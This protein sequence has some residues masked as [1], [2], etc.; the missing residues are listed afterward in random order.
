MSANI[1]CLRRLHA[2]GAAIP[3][4]R[5]DARRGTTTE[6][7]QNGAAWMSLDLSADTEYGVIKVG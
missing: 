5:L 2:A 6:N 4:V 3:L 7:C 1:D